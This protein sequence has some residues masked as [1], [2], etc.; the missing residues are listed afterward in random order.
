MA[1]QERIQLKEKLSYGVGDTACC[2]I[3]NL[4]SSYISYYLTDIAAISVI[5]AGQIISIARL[6]DAFVNPV[7]GL[8]IDRTNTRWGKARPFMLFTAVPLGVSC[9]LLFR[10]AELSG[11][12]GRMVYAFV[13]YLLFC[14]LYTAYNVPYSAL[15]PNITDVEEERLKMNS[16]RFSMVT[17]GS[18]VAMGLPLTL[19]EL[20]GQG[21]EAK[22]FSRVGLLFGL[23]AI[24]LMLVCFQ[25]TRERIRPKGTASLRDAMLIICK[26]NPWL[27]LGLTQLVSFV[28]TTT[29]N[30]ATVYYAQYYLNHR[31]W[32]S[33]L[34]T[35]GALGSLS[36]V[37]LG[38]PLIRRFGK[39][40]CTL[41]GAAAFIGGC[42]VIGVSGKNF[43]LI[44]IG[45]LFASVGGSI[46][47]CVSYLMLTDTIDYGE[48][49]TGKRQQGILTATMMFMNK[50]GIMLSGV[51]SAWVLDF[52][53]YVS[54][55][56]QT[57]RALTGIRTAYIY[58]PMAVMLLCF[59][60]LYFYR[61]DLRREE[62][63]E[64][65]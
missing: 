31:D 38:N 30:S 22:G 13:V 5:A 34:L 41:I 53:G 10:T 65:S 40:G 55:Q 58:L 50:M 12:T 7:M 19:V 35:V 59:V 9:M 1:A 44:F 62:E 43:P 54:N 52:F 51:L 4:V 18:L 60:F 21:D 8:A 14:L 17:V 56:A 27:M 45:N 61:L 63:G 3:F 64:N 26:N 32:A 49:I 15:L 24:V 6:I 29:R 25:N 37:I 47:P 39:K 48:Q 33:I 23:I 42:L 28:A 20:F 46:I 16:Y 2:L 57:P 11:K 36:A